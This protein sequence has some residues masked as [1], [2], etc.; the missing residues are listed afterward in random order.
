MNKLIDTR[1]GKMLINENDNCIG[2]S[3]VI[4]GEW[5]QGEMDF[6]AQFISPG[7]ICLDVGA[8]IGCHTLHFAKLCGA[9]GGVI[10]FEPQHAVFQ[11]LCANSA[12]NNFFNVKAVN[13]AVGKGS[14]T[15]MVPAIDYAKP[16]NF[17]A[18]TLNSQPV[19]YPVA[20]VALD[21]SAN[22]IPTKLIKIDVEGFECDV[23]KGAKHLIK[24]SRPFIYAENNRP[25]K[26]LELL[27]LLKN[28]KYDVYDHK[29]K[30]WNPN[31]FNKNTENMHGD[32]TESNIFCVPQE[33]NI[34]IPLP[35]L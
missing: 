1:Y 13:C 33:K 20:I 18:V 32:Y 19:A 30:G 26:T 12:L 22:G 27:G 4:D 15:V 29:V 24:T 10:S 28:M 6:L 9:E 8:N 25:E 17:G 16:G 2:K 23:I 21:D 7:D 14:G 11:L 34:S 3:L 5:Y 35:Q 31:N